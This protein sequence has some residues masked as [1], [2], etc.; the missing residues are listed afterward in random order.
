MR[1]SAKAADREANIMY[2]EPPAYPRPVAGGWA[3]I[4]LALGDQA[5]AEKAYRDALKR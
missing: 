3:N 2:T 4:A 1:C 5:T